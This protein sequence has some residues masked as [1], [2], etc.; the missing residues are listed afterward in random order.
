MRE[1]V[2][3][4]EVTGMP[5]EAF[6]EDGSRNLDWEP[7]GWPA[8]REELKKAGLMRPDETRFF[9]PRTDRIYQSKSTAQS[10]VRLMEKYGATAHVV[11]SRLEWEDVRE[12]EA[13]RKRERELARARK[14]R[15]KADDIEANAYGG[16]LAS[17]SAELREALADLKEVL[18]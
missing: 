7:E 10:R 12:A 9:W 8:Y 2:Y 5:K 15:A 16:Q 14:L 1:Y 11:Q 17:A 6:S 3:A 4:V 18:G 13:A